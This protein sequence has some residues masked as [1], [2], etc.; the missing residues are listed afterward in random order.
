MAEI[1]H[2]VD[3]NNQSHPR[4]K[5]MRDVIPVP[6][7]A[8]SRVEIASKLRKAGI[9]SRVDDS[10]TSI[11]KRYARNDELGRNVILWT[12]RDQRIGSIDEVIVIGTD[13]VDGNIDWVGACQRL[14]AYDGVEAIEA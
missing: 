4:L 14:P 2:F 1:E 9:F 12:N 6:A 10:N 13:L 3:S 8:H 7:P 11:G 5:E